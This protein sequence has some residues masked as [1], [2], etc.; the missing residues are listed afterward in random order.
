MRVRRR[1]A[2]LALALAVTAPGCVSAGAGDVSADDLDDLAR[3]TALE[4][5]RFLDRSTM[6]GRELLVV[7]VVEDDHRY[8]ATVSIDGTPVYDEIV[9][10]DARYLRVL[11]PTELAPGGDVAALVAVD[12]A[13]AQVATG[14]WVVDADGAP[15]EFVQGDR[16]PPV[17][18]SPQLVLQR[19][20]ALDEWDAL[21]PADPQEWNPD[22]VTYLPKDDK[23]DEHGS[24]GTRFDVIPPAY[25][26]NRI[27]TTMG[28]IEEQFQYTSVWAGRG[29]ITRV[30]QLLE[31]PD[32]DKDTYAELYR[33]ITRAGS[34]SL[35][36]LVRTGVRLPL[37]RV[38]EI[39]VPDD[40]PAVT[41]PEVA[42]PVDLQPALAKLAQTFAAAVKVPG[43]LTGRPT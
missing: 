6:A 16:L 17:P 37:R 21:V 4:P 24:F 34:E 39:E 10:D 31:F 23:F 36:H 38:I 2:A 18:L 27:I 19:V 28:A 12:P 35:Q 26:P 40:P 1:L 3:A 15:P 22:A 33:Q 43:P 9:V 30:E 29:H 41:V 20:R 8:S 11:D 13:L 42:E 32:P 25:D 14:A 5:R 7:G